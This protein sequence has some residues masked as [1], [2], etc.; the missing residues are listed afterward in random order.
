MIE[1]GLGTVKEN[2]PVDP[3][4]VQAADEPLKFL[5]HQ[6]RRWLDHSLVPID[7]A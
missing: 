5:F 2:R 6:N 7:P 4:L 3:I 1:T